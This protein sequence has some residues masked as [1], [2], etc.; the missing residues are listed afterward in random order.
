MNVKVLTPSPPLLPYIEAYYFTSP[1][2][3]PHHPTAHF[4]AGSR[5]YVKFSPPSGILSGQTTLPAEIVTDWETEG[6][7]IKLRMGAVYALFGIPA[8]AITNRVVDLEDVLGNTA[9][10][11]AERI[12]T[13]STLAKKIRH[14]EEVFA[15][16]TLKSDKKSFSTELA[17]LQVLAN[18]RSSTISR[19]A[20]QLGY[21]PRQ[22]QRKMN[23]FIGLTPRLFK[24]ISRFEKAC[25]LIQTSAR[26]EGP[27]W[28]DIAFLCGYSDQAHFIRDFREFAGYTPAAFVSDP[29][30][31]DPFNTHG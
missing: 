17:A 6:F 10:E 29:D 28:S 2:T 30:L 5:S 27:A 24:R 19:L 22:L 14:V 26:K 13:S 8:H 1:D 7:G 4:P 11:L 18:G 25:R 3:P 21:S 9:H 20:E 23:D 16:L 15:R 31:S 12:A